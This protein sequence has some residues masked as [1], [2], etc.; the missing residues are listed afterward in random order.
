VDSKN[1]EITSGTDAD[2]VSYVDNP[3]EYSRIF[4]TTRYGAVRDVVLYKAVD[5]ASA[6]KN[7]A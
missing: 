6:G 5:Y 7:G 1:N 3:D 2:I 4:I